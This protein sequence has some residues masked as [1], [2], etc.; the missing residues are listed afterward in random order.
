M[1]PYLSYLGIATI[2]SILA[3]NSPLPLEGVS[4]KPLGTLLYQLAFPMPHLEPPQPPLPRGEQ[5]ENRGQTKTQLLLQV[6][7]TETEESEAVRL[8]EQGRK[9]LAT[10]QLQEALKTFQQVLAIRQ[11][12]G[13]RT[14][15]AEVLNDL[16][17]VYNDLSQ[18]DRAL[19]SLQQALSI[20][21]QISDR[22]G[23][24][25]T[26]SLLGEVYNN[27]GQPAK[28]LEILKQA[29]AIDK[30]VS[31]RLGEGKTHYRLGNV[32]ISLSQQDEALDS[33]QKALSIHREVRDGISEGRTLQ[34]I[35]LVYRRQGEYDRAMEFYQQA[36][37]INQSIGDVLGQGRT[38]NGIGAVYYSLGQ[39]PKALE[40]YQQALAI[41]QSIGDRI[42]EVGSLNSIG[43]VR[44]RLGEYDE[45]L[46][47]Y[48][49]ALE[50]A[51]AI[52]SPASEV[53]S[54]SNFGGVYYSLGQYPKALEFYQ[55]AL[56]IAK[57]IN[58]R[59]DEGN[60]LS[61][62]GGIYNELGQYSQALEFYRQALTIRRDISDRSGEANTLNHIGGVY[63]NLG[64]QFRALESYQEAYKIRRDIGDRSGE[65]ATLNN[66]GLVYDNQGQ[67]AQALQFYQQALAILQ[68]V[69][70]RSGAG[71]TLNNIGIIYYK[72][73]QS[74]ESLE[75]FQQALGLL[76]EIG[77]LSGE[78]MTLSNIGDWLARENE[79]ELAIAFYKQSVN[80]TETIRRN[81][82]V[83]PREQQESY[84]QTVADVYRRLADLLLSQGR[85]LEAQQVLELLKIEEL[86]DFT[87]EARAGGQ[88]DGTALTPIEEQILKKH[89]SLIAFG[90]Q[91]DEC[92]RT[93]CN[94]LRQLNA[95]LQVLNQEYD[96]TAQSITA[97]IRSNL[98]IDRASFDP[99]DLPRKAREIVEAQPNTVLIYPFVLQNKLWILWA[100]QGG[101][102]NKYE[103]SGIGQQ[104]LGETVLRFRQLLQNPGSSVSQVK[105]TGKQL[106]DWLIQPLE[107]ELKANG[108][109]N[110]VFSL[111]RVTRYIPMSALFDGKNYLVENY[112]ISTILSADL[113]DVRDRLPPSQNT[114][115]LALGLSE[116]VEGFN[117]LPNVPVELDAIVKKDPTDERGI[118]PGEKFLN[119]DF[120]FPTLQD[121]LL[122]HQILH[123][124]THGQF[125]PGRPDDS[126][127]VLGT[128]EKLKIPD[129]RTLQDLSNIHLVVL[130]ACETALGGPDR[131]GVEIAGI[132][133]YFL[134][135]GTKAVMASLW[136]V[137]D[138][139]TSLLMQRFYGNLANATAQNPVTKV[140][141]LRQAQ[142]SLLNGENST[143]ANTNQR[144]LRIENLSGTPGS[145]S[146]NTR[147]KFAH[148][149]YWASFIL[150]G[151]GL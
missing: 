131:D 94:Q 5:L 68:S 88:T 124:A 127:L 60:T 81:L 96:K 4:P 41:R 10:G 87:R 76:R 47:F 132:S 129:I 54:L 69:G 142:L 49:Q 114:S 92:K 50:I 75:S 39:Y 95:Q 140:Q 91:V 58:D 65:G 147:S 27:L 110:L 59:A 40:F 67:Y 135:A 66:I 90:R 64:Q 104:Q 133:Y 144:G 42:G 8:S 6:Q 38:L 123:I 111:D 82:R 143:A 37:G 22:R 99:E 141:A 105:A 86:R 102:V 33:L 103:V 128:G 112:S 25:E 151:N 16:G 119:S 57:T 80:V 106:Y 78:S 34:T 9:Q 107:A 48:K 63:R 101:V 146:A 55:Q 93:R 53:N 136:L 109:K 130:S 120:N 13:T 17:E 98:T 145:T 74:S 113:T 44:A 72:L 1:Y 21:R 150:I 11:K 148:P 71:L 122:T 89:N 85:V 51:K 139:S 28:A 134:N 121:N 12:I 117:P 138:T 73:G 83:L 24:G 36:L 70:D 125:I 52:G 79:P 32:Y 84:T 23:E 118:Y 26:Q 29:L 14:E 18:Y 61:N 35:G 137:N 115:V 108:I 7:T 31:N 2:S 30:A 62:I 20:R 149:Y 46:K 56:A 97:E 45:A 19:E 77:N 43:I 100:S 126:F 3:L 116:A 15:Q